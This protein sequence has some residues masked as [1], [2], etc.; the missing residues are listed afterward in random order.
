MVLHIKKRKNIFINFFNKSNEG[1]KFWLNWNLNKFQ[2]LG[3]I[4]KE[5]G[6]EIEK[7]EGALKEIGFLWKNEREI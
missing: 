2:V 4:S 7:K 6:K 5:A 3:K 1:E